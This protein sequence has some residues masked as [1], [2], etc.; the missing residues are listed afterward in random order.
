MTCRRMRCAPMP[1]SDDSVQSIAGIGM[2]PPPSHT[3]SL[4]KLLDITMPVH[5]GAL[6]RPEAGYRVPQ[7]LTS[8]TLSCGH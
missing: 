2:R 7:M 5:Y 6:E 4:G 1:A 3:P 8:L